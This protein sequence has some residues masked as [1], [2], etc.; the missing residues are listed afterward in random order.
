MSFKNFTCDKYN[1][2]KTFKLIQI[3][4]PCSLC[5]FPFIH[6]CES[7]QISA[8]TE[9]WEEKKNVEHQANS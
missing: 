3:P 8:K 1:P 9:G 7:I 4:V 2:I 6:F 5:V